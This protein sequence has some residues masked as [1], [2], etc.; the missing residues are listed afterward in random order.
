VRNDR[1]ERAA[2][3]RRRAALCREAARYPTPGGHLENRI[4]EELAR[5]FEWRAE[6]IEA[7]G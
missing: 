6:E 3:L 5:E 1:A 7:S 2:E 4:L